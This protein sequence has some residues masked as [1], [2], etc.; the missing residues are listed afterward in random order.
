MIIKSLSRKK[1]TFFQ[2]Y[3]YM[4]EGADD[5]EFIISK[6]LY[7]T[8]SRK[9]VL[10]QFTKN[11][12]LLPKRKNG[13]ALYHEIISLPYQKDIPIKKQKEMLYNMANHYLE[14]RTGLNI[15]F[16]VIHEEKEHLH[17]HLMIS[18]NEKHSSQ[19][20]RL[21]KEQF[22]QLQKDLENY[23]QQNFPELEDKVLYNK[24]RTKNRYQSSKSKDREYQLKHRTKEPSRK[25]ILKEITAEIILDSYS[26]EQLIKKLKAQNLEFYQRGKTAGIID[27]EE[28]EQEKTKHKHRFKTLGLEEEYQNF[29]EFEKVKEQENELSKEDREQDFD[30]ERD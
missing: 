5:K 4:L 30:L 11:H 26:K 1:P 19:R 8:N 21:P 3:D 20:Q 17:C 12:N 29:L 22:A 9:E 18:S 7:Q 25:D 6:N 24:E 14:H 23:K 10:K 13:N 2:L 28:K 16:G 27:L 15:S